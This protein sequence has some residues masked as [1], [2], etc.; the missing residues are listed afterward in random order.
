MRSSCRGKSISQYSLTTARVAITGIGCAFPIMGC[1][2]FL[3]TERRWREEM[4]K[5]CRTGLDDRC[6]DQDGEIRRKNGATRVATLRETYGDN[7]A[8]GFRSDMKLDTL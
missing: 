8:S 4:A 5:K 3:F 6:R 1:V 7:F 2:S